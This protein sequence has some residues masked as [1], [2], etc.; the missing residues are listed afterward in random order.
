[1]EQLLNVNNQFSGNYSCHLNGDDYNKA[2]TAGPTNETL[3]TNEIW[4]ADHWTL[5]WLFA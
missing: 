2:M 1:M 3:L 5:S 4:A